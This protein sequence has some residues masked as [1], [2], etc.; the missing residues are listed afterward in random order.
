[1]LSNQGRCP[2]TGWGEDWRNCGCLA[3][4][5]KAVPSYEGGTQSSGEVALEDLWVSSNG[6]DPSNDGDGTG[7]SGLERCAGRAMGS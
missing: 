4:E 5:R 1:M 2:V 3:T 7:E 6:E